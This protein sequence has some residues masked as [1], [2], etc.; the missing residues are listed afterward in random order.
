MIN[1]AV[2]SIDCGT[3]RLGCDLAAGKKWTLLEIGAE[4]CWRD[5]KSICVSCQEGPV[6]IAITWKLKSG[7][8]AY[9]DMNHQRV[10][11]Q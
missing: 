6:V 3:S 4:H 7:E 9:M 8:R 11:P 1:F 2:Q 5:G 10:G